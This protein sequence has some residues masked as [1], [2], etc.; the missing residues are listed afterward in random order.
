MPFRPSPGFTVG[1]EMEFQLVDPCGG[2]LVDGIL[3]LLEEL[4]A[5]GVIGPEGASIKPEVFQCTV[6]VVSPPAADLAE[7]EAALRPQLR[8]LLERCGR[9]GMAVCGAGTHP[10]SR[11]PALFTPG[12]RY[13]AMARGAGWLGHNQVTFATH[14]HLGLADGEEAVRLM[15]EITPY[16][17][18]LIAL[19]ASS[20]FWHGTDTRFAA[21]RPRVLAATR[22]FGPPPEFPHWMAF[23][24]FFATMRRAGLLQGLRDLHWDLRPRPD[25]GTLEVRVM[26]AQPS[27]AEALALAA[28]LRALA[29]F[30][31]RTRGSGEGER[32]LR[33]LFWWYRKENAYGA[34]RFGLE[35]RLIVSD[36]GEVAPLRQVARS[37]LERIAPHAGPGEG[38]HLERLERRIA[39]GLLPYERQR[40]R[41]AGTGSMNAVVGGLVEELRDDLA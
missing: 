3:P 40:H 11:R 24:R 33:P 41:Y 2:D 13:R 16:L 20:P 4:G 32:P 36:E 38:P 31:Q 23:E 12:R 35:A 9:L 30:L 19:S 17:P 10:F 37:T 28:L 18:L 5:K 29:R 26:D 21:F 6:E 22:S 34:S 8:E 15:A 39:S 14:V 25:L 27:L 7:L 1:M